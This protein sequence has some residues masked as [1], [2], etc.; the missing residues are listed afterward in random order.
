M[1]PVPPE[2]VYKA[3]D[4][5]AMELRAAG[6]QRVADILHHRLHKVAWSTKDELL[7]ELQKV[8]H[9][10]EVSVSGPLKQKIEQVASVIAQCL[11]MPRP[12]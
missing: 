3:I 5:L 2:D 1:T 12:K 6:Y 4:E 9:A 7:E 10:T 8:L 11:S